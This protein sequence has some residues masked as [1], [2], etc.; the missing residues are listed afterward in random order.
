MRKRVKKVKPPVGCYMSRLSDETLHKL[1]RLR[2]IF[3]M[4]GHA[5]TVVSVFLSQ[6]CMNYAFEIKWLLTLY[7]TVFLVM[8]VVF[9]WAGVFTFR[10]GKIA[11]TITEKVVPKRGLDTWRTFPALELQAVLSLVWFG[12]QIGLVSVW[13]DLGGLFITLIAG[14]VTASCVAVWVVTVKAWRNNAE[15]RPPQPVEAKIDVLPEEIED[16]FAGSAESGDVSH[17]SDDF[18]QS[19]EDSEREETL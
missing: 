9:V 18:Y 14:I 12:L 7:L 10:R 19:P 4:L 17:P 8:L 2:A 6:D 5:L 1:Q 15:Y 13:Y 3:L 16:F 11:R